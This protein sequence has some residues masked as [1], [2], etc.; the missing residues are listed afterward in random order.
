ME[1]NHHT[2]HYG[3]EWSL[4]KESKSLME[5]PAL[6]QNMHFELHTALHDECPGVPV[7]NFHTV[8][9]AKSLW[10]PGHNILES[11]DS[12]AMAFEDAIHHPKAHPI[13]RRLGELTIDALLLQRPFLRLSLG[14]RA[15]Q[16][17]HQ[18]SIPL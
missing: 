4:R 13:E 2:L 18:T 17:Y 16:A 14:K 12:L 7:P 5:H 11:I 15:V 10:I 9:R 3:K 6:I 1:T 8:Q